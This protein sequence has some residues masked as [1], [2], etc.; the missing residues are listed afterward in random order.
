MPPIQLFCHSRR[1]VSG[2]NLI[3]D[4]AFACQ[5]AGSL[6]VTDGPHSERFGEGD[7]R[8]SVRN[9]LAKFIKQPPLQGDY[10]SLSIAFD[11]ATLRDFSREYGIRAAK[12]PATFPVLRLN[13]HPLYQHL[14]VSLT[15]YLPF[16]TVQDDGLVKLKLKETLLTLIRVQPE[17]ADILFDFSEPTKLDLAAFMDQNF[18]FNLK[19]SRFAYLTGRSLSA[20]KRDFEQVYQV[21]PGHWLVQK[22]LQEAYYLINEKRYTPSEVYLEVGFEDLSHFS[23]AFK[24]QFGLAP[25]ALLG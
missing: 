21:T 25:S 10:Q 8:L 3:A 24:K 5:L 23:Y 2:E 11:Q 7:F 12:K 18:R 13:S 22:R 9:R 4:H 17:L 16:S 15:P 6:T 20:F 14:V 1:S 19:L